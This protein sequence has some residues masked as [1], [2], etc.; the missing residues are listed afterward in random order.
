MSVVRVLGFV[1]LSSALAACEWTMQTGSERGASRGA[2]TAAVCG[3]AG[4]SC[5]TGT[6]A[7]C[8]A[9]IDRWKELLVIHRSVLLDRRARNDVD[10]APWSFRSRMVE[11][12]GGD[13]TAAKDLAHVW[14]D[15]WRTVTSVGPDHAPVTPRPGIASV[16]IDPWIA[17]SNGALTS[18]P[19]RLIAIVNRPDLREHD[20]G[21][22][23][24]AGELRFVYTAVAPVERHALPMTVIFEV[25]YPATRSAR[26]WI[27]TWHALAA[28]PFG[29]E[30]TTALAALTT[31][32][33]KSS[34]PASWV[35]RTNEDAFGVA[36]ALPWEMREFALRTDAYEARRLV[37][38]PIA[39]TPRI[40]LDRSPSLDAW[41]KQNE[42]RV[43]DGTYVLPGGFQAG[44]APIANASFRWSSSSVDQTALSALNKTTCN[45]CHGGERDGETSLPFQHLAAPDQRAN[46]YYSAA[47]DGE[48]QVSGWLDS[49][50]RHDDELSRR[51][52][53]MA[54]ALCD[55]CGGASPD[56]QPY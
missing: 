39:T 45:G 46:A 54:R 1:L 4:E 29:S 43:L 52:D 38:V 34:P 11:L 25:P 13:E 12:A 7:T 30:Y 20:D 17:Q 24:R 36:S 19:F 27:E 14:L 44:A 37:Q 23:G 48:T 16:L 3:R 41:L 9:K 22:D 42:A 21:C 55:S 28:L 33:T 50:S 31:E 47:T 51:E 49:R 18:A 6:G 10:D 56:R 35:V 26:G 53:S 32:V 8:D 40:E 2:S 15:Q 5:A